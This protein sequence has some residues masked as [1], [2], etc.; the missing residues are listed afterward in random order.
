MDST[1]DNMIANEVANPLRMLSAM[2]KIVLCDEQVVNM[3]Q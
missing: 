3:R 1:Q 2:K